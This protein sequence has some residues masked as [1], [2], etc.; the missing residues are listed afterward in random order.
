MQ[1]FTRVPESKHH[2]GKTANFVIVTKQPI[3]KR[4]KMTLQNFTRV[5]E[6]KH[7]RG[8]TANFVI[9]TKQPILKRNKMTHFRSVP[10]DLISYGDTRAEAERRVIT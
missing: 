9:V 5:P 7:H 6:S 4:N 2:R 8:K 1:N 10:K 3:L